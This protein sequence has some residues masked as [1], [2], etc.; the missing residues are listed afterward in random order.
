MTQEK[1]RTAAFKVPSWL[2]LWFSPIHLLGKGYDRLMATFWPPLLVCGNMSQRTERGQV[3]PFRMLPA[4]LQH[5]CAKVVGLTSG[6]WPLLFAI[7]CFL[8]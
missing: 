6:K 4:K 1:A 7:F 3:S 2:K 8:L 5:H